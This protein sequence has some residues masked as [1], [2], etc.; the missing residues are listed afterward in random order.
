MKSWKKPAVA[1][2]KAE[3]LSDVVKACA[4]TCFNGHLR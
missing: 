1:M 4:F 2:V 3:H